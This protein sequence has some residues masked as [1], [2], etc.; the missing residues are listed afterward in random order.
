MNSSIEFFY[1]R[2]FTVFAGEHGFSPKSRHIFN[3]GH[4]YDGDFVGERKAID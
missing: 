4:L 1:W 2:F 3:R